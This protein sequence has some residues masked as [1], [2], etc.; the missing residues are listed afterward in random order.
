MEKLLDDATFDEGAQE[1]P[2]PDRAALAHPSL[3]N[4][5]VCHW[6]SA[7][8]DMFAERWLCE[9]QG[10]VLKPDLTQEK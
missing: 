10:W 3:A 1:H 5:H 8:G 9:C 6:Q 7:R 2:H 4:V